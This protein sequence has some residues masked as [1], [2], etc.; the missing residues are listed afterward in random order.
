[1]VAKTTAKVFL[2]FVFFA[3]FAGESIAQ[4]FLPELVKRIKPSAVEIE[5]F[6]L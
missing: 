5:T 4:D 2:F 6:D 1:M 3:C